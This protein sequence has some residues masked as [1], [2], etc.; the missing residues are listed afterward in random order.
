[1]TNLFLFIVQVLK[2]FLHVFRADVVKPYPCSNQGI[3][4]EAGAFLSLRPSLDWRRRI[5]CVRF[6]NERCRSK[7]HIF[8]LYAVFSWVPANTHR[9]RHGI[10]MLLPLVNRDMGDAW[11]SVL[12]PRDSPSSLQWALQRHRKR[13]DL[14]LPVHRAGSSVA[15]AIHWRRRLVTLS[16]FCPWNPF[17]SWRIY[18]VRTTTGFNRRI[19]GMLFPDEQCGCMFHIFKLHA[20]FPGY[21]DKQCRT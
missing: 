4:F 13:Y 15:S 7:F 3:H 6:R 9:T 18:I 19:K 10:D 2:L 8:S 17:L 5:M 1:M 11:I 16:M 20:V 12:K 21:P 14:S